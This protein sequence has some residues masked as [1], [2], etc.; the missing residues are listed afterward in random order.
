MPQPSSGSSSKTGS[1]VLAT[2]IRDRRHQLG[3][4]RH[5]LAEATGV[6][7]STIAQIETAYRGVSPSRLGVIARTLQLDPAEL[8]D[9]LAAE[10]ASSAASAS[11]AGPD[12][13]AGTNV[14]SWHANPVY[15]TAMR[16]PAAAAPAGPPAAPPGTPEPE[17]ISHI[18]KLLSQLPATRRLDALGQVQARLM[19][20]L[21]HDE[22]QRMTRANE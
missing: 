13:A 1:T 8:Y 16:Q 7:Y 21:V 10:P 22:V 3:L 9:V 18:V 12:Q 5:E 2:L 17:I 14:D 6:P 4:S 11:A 20:D 19:A 15:V